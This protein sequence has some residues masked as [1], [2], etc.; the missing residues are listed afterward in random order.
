MVSGN[1]QERNV[2]DRNNGE[3]EPRAPH[4]SMDKK[5]YHGQ[6]NIVLGICCIGNIS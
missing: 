4:I 3:S 1:G 5:R 2:T 6:G